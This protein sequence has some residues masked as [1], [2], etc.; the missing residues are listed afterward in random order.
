MFL[1][2]YE[3][4]FSKLINKSIT[5]KLFCYKLFNSGFFYKAAKFIEIRT[6]EPIR[7]YYWLKSLI[8]LLRDSIEKRLKRLPMLDSFSSTILKLLFL[9]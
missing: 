7:V 1:Q 8:F 4:K 9:I 6:I 3:L 2:T 5:F